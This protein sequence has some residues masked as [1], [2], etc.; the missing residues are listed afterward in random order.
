MSR[1]G[2]SID[3]EVHGRG[4]SLKR[5]DESWNDLLSRAFD[6]LEQADA[7]PGDA[8]A[9]RDRL[10]ELPD[11]LLTEDHIP[12]IGADVERRVERILDDRL[13]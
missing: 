3:D 13:R 6:A 7:D 1:S 9:A 2:I 10:D 4:K 5:D 8:D 12:D 11:T